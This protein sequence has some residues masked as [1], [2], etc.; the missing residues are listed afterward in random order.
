MS[1]A[2]C[3]PLI[4]SRHGCLND[5]A[6][7]DRELDEERVVLARGLL[8]DSVCGRRHACRCPIAGAVC[9]ECERSVW[10]HGGRLFTVRGSL[11]YC[12]HDGIMCNLFLS[13]LQ[14]FFASL[15]VWWMSL[16]HLDRL[17]WALERLFAS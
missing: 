6:T 8:K 9:L 10:E 11:P 17:C 13:D 15:I 12:L 2:S 5:Y 14:H 16:L 7:K 4:T 1:D 3:A